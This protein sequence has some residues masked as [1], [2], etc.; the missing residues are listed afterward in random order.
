MSTALLVLDRRCVYWWDACRFSQWSQPV[1]V[2][3]KKNAKK[4]LISS[5][6]IWWRLILVVLA[7]LTLWSALS[8]VGK[9]AL[10]LISKCHTP[11]RFVLRETHRWWMNNGRLD[12]SVRPR[13]WKSARFSR[14]TLS[15]NFILKSCRFLV[16]KVK[17]ELKR[18]LSSATLSVGGSE[19]PRRAEFVSVN[20]YNWTFLAGSLHRWLNFSLNQI[21]TFLPFWKCQVIFDSL[22]AFS[23]QR[24]ALPVCVAAFKCNIL[25]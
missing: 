10:S 18:L 12:S 13:G 9:K 4:T 20:K 8:P 17:N 5:Y 14:E 24:A 11:K 2:K 15:P 23:K 1:W 21:V 6:F 22:G 19:T 7:L 3:K 16:S 25:K